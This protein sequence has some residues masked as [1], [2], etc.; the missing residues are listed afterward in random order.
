MIMQFFVK[1][2]LW[3]KLYISHLS[4]S[5]EHKWRMDGN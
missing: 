1:H 2:I 5:C 4:W 3:I